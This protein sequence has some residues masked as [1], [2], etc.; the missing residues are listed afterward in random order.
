MFG[1]AAASLVQALEEEFQKTKEAAAQAAKEAA[2]A[3]A[4]LGFTSL[5]V[6]LAGSCELHAPQL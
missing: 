3:K 6:W 4:S 5:A 2:A 1:D